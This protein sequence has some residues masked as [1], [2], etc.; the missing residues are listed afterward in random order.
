MTATGLGERR[1]RRGTLVSDRRGILEPDAGAA[2][3]RLVRH[4]PAVDL[5]DLVERHWVVSWDLR[6]RPPFRQ[7]ILPHPCVHLVFEPAGPAVYGVNNGPTGHLLN[8]RGVVLGTKFR[9]GGFSPFSAVPVVS[10]TDRAVPLAEAL[11]PDGERLEDDVL[12]LRDADVAGRIEVVE[13]FLRARRPAPDEQ[14]ETV[15]RIAQAMRTGSPTQRVA[16]VAAEHGLSVRT[17]QRLFRTHAG[18][19]PKWVLQRYRLHEAAERMAA[20][21]TDDWAALALELG[22]FDQAHFIND[23]RSW[24]GTTPAEYAAACRAAAGREPAA[25]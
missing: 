22:Y 1:Q 3:F 4:L 24:I 20:G 18:V 12:A 6:G 2:R 8:G 19:S 11:G 9:P 14:V 13:A 16:E 25:A 15:V 21:E 17:L 23:F 5:R 7:R 10:L